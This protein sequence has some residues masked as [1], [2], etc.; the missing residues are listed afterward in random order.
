MDTTSVSLLHRVRVPSDQEAW[1]RFVDL[2]TPMIYRW[3]LD[4]GLPKSDASDLV[5]DIFLT[6][7]EKLPSFE[8]DESKNF[9]GW[10]KAV[11]AN[12]TKDFLRRRNR[13]AVKGG[14]FVSKVLSPDNVEFMTDQEYNQH[15]T[16]R[17]AEFMKAEFEERTWQACWRTYVEGESIAKVA[18][19]LAMTPNAVYVARSKV[20][21]RLRSELEGLL[22][23]D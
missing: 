15:L 1:N 7:S 10:L 6:L 23:E 2:Y 22:T 9:R 20:L 12:R 19:S 17:I 21:R 3:A 11:T 5:Q 18:E 8:Y 4:I 13:Q 16:A 14:S